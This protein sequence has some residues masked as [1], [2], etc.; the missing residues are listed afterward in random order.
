VGECE[1]ASQVVGATDREGRAIRESKWNDVFSCLVICHSRA[2]VWDGWGGGKTWK[3]TARK[4][5]EKLGGTDKRYRYPDLGVASGAK[6][7]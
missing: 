6:W 2:G 4:R 7:P 1:L 3:A 5:R